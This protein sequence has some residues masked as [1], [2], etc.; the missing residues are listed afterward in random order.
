VLRSPRG[1]LFVGTPQEVVDK[2]LFQHEIF[3]HQRFLMQISVGTMPH[4]NVLR[5]I[6]LFG[7]EVAPRVRKEI[8]GSRSQ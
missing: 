5:A 7:T 8:E 4:R 6:E 2:I 3:G 1:A